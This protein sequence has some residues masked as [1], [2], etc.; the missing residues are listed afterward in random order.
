MKTHSEA[1]SLVK[2]LHQ[3]RPAIFWTDLLLSAVAGWG[4]V[5][6]VLLA[7][8]FSATMW[9]GFVIAT[10]ALYRGLCFLHEISHIRRS[11]LRGFETTWNLIF[12]VPLL[13]PSF[14]YIGVHSNHHGLATYGT[15][16]DP[17]YLP[18]AQ[19]HWMSIVFA[20][21]SVLI[22]LALL[23]RFLVLAP[24][25]LLWPRFHHW[26]VVHASSLSMN[27]RYRREDSPVADRLDAALGGR[28]S[29]GLAGSRRHGLALRSCLEGSG[30]LVW[31]QCMRRR[32][33]MPCALWE[34]IVTKVPAC[35]SIAEVNC[36][37][38]STRPALCGPHL[39]APVGLRYHALHHYFPGIPYHHLG[40]A[41]RRLISSLS[42][43]AAYQ[44]LTSPSLPR[45]LRRLYR[46]GKNVQQ[47]KRSAQLYV[48]PPVRSSGTLTHFGIIG[49]PV[50]GH[51][52]PFLALA[53][54][55]QERGHR[56]T[57]FQI[58]DLEA[59]SSLGGDRF[60]SHRSQRSPARIASGFAGAIGQA[61]GPG[62]L[63]LHRP[64]HSAHHRNDLPGRS[65]GSKKRACRRTPGGSDRTRRRERRGIFGIAVRNDLQRAG[66]E[67]R[68]GRASCLHALGLSRYMVGENAKPAGECCLGSH[69]RAGSA[70]ARRAS[71]ALET[72]RSSKFRRYILAAC[73]DQS[74]TARV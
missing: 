47:K 34:P 58:P 68:T 28:D 21:H 27:T 71:G 22:P 6:V 36:S 74:A 67:S 37:T 44:E 8:P 33:P 18:F 42:A 70:H 11:H 3:P 55:L 48:E 15:D 61:F 20:A 52:N 50:P 51:V 30:N 35:L 23:L 29:A 62:R 24:A 26:L 41:Y 25:G 49:P 43:E 32:W 65:G 64:R 60:L 16:Q 10:C 19:S 5:G 40:T 39:W 54:E 45:S 69:S 13:M 66:A 17:E 1:W 59:A 2:D 9:L 7:K 57:F 63:A 31:R 4:G 56:V 14:V 73:A 53:H 38:R 72:A 46:S 12:G